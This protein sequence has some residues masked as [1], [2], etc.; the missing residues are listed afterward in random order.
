MSTCALRANKEGTRAELHGQHG[1]S[2]SAPRLP[3]GKA[4]R[5]ADFRG[6]G[7]ELGTRRSSLDL[8]DREVPGRR[9]ARGRPRCRAGVAGGQIQNF[10]VANGTPSSSATFG[11]NNPPECSSRARSGQSAGHD[12]RTV[13]A[14][15]GRGWS[16]GSGLRPGAA[17]K[18]LILVPPASIVDRGELRR[19]ETR[20]KRI[21]ASAARRLFSDGRRNR[22]SRS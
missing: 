19:C 2:G 5:P 18:D 11:Q 14:N 3:D 7:T 4:C 12:C 21:I 17:P 16:F 15:V 6:S 1:L 10:A 20:S 13:R 22:S 9:G 8:A